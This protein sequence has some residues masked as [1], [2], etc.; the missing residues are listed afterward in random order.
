MKWSAGVEILGSGTLLTVHCVEE[1][2]FPRVAPR[3]VLLEIFRKPYAPAPWEGE[4][5]KVA[6]AGRLGGPEDK[7]TLRDAV[8]AGEEVRIEDLTEALR[9]MNPV[10]W[11]KDYEGWFALAG[12]VKAVGISRADFIDWCVRDPHY[13]ADRK[14]IGR[15][16]DS[17]YGKHGRAFYKALAQRRI[18]VS[19]S[20][21]NTPSSPSLYPRVRSAN[22]QPFGHPSKTVNVI[23]R[24]NHTC[25]G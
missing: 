2:L 18:K 23:A 21:N 22:P 14:S 8:R 16:W 6:H 19:P 10:D 4:T 5:G 24:T 9:Q 25:R 20:P 1:I 11:R 17:A 7:E 13:A 3:A 12:A 15:I